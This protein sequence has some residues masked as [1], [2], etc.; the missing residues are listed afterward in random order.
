MT[1]AKEQEIEIIRVHDAYW[2]YYIKGDVEAM[3]DL[4]D[5]EYTQVGSAEDEDFFVVKLKRYLCGLCVSAVTF[6]FLRFHR[7]CGS[8]THSPVLRSEKK[9]TPRC[10]CGAQPQ[11]PSRDWQPVS[12][13]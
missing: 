7:N 11:V 1:L 13:P 2:D 8:K 6:D 12:P 3:R 5:D 4:L 10:S 9:T